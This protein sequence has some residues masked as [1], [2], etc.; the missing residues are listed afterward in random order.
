MVDAKMLAD[1]EQ[2]GAQ[3]VT[4]VPVME[5]DQIKE[6]MS[7]Q[8]DSGGT[9]EGTSN[10]AESQLKPSMTDSPVKG[11]EKV[12]QD[13]NVNLLAASTEIMRPLSF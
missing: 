9:S 13:P 6:G 11:G 12:K 2:K 4:K 5:S 1:Y 8:P 3:A 7:E 10:K